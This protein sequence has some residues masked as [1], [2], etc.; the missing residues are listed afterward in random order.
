MTPS[1]V[2]GLEP[3]GLIGKIYVGDYN[4]L[5]RTQ[6]ISCGP[7]GFREEDIFF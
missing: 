1:G 6:Y 4:T 5:L 3:R 7:H 2:A